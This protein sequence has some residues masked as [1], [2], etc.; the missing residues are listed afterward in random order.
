MTL[1]A[2]ALFSWLMRHKTKLPDDLWQR[3]EGALRVAEG[4]IGSKQRLTAVA[5]ERAKPICR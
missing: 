1:S 5:P 4:Q 2:S 3:I